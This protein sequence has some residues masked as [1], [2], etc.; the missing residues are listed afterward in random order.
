MPKLLRG[1][2]DR[3]PLVSSKKEQNDVKDYSKD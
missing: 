2:A 1:L 3:A